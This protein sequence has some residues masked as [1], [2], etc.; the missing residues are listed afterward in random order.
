MKRIKIALSEVKWDDESLPKDFNVFIPSNTPGWAII[1]TI[2]E[3]CIQKFGEYP[4][5]FSMEI[6]ERS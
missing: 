6:P 2:R 3:K 5:S 4:W 1:Q